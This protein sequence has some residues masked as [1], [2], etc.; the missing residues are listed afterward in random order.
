MGC[1]HGVRIW[2][3][4]H[5]LQTLIMVSH[6]MNLTTEQRGDICAMIGDLIVQGV[7]AGAGHDINEAYQYYKEAADCGSSYAVERMNSL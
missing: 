3:P 2:L 7:G 1:I 5:D 6:N 4:E